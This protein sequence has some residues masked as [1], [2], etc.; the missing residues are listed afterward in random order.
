MEREFVVVRVRGAASE[1][2]K[3]LTMEHQT[4]DEGWTKKRDE[5]WSGTFEEA[6]LRA[7]DAND[8]FR[9]EQHWFAMAIAKS[10]RNEALQLEQ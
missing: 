3:A 8:Q 7:A 1:D 5:A 2:E 6:Q 10:P 4:R 9:R